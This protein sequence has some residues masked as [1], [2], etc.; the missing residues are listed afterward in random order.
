MLPQFHFSR[1]NLTGYQNTVPR[2]VNVFV[3][4]NEPDGQGK[5]LT[6]KLY[7]GLAI[8]LNSI[9]STKVQFMNEI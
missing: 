8:I 4:T 3:S 2:T 7:A 1:D 5:I 9:L 6:L